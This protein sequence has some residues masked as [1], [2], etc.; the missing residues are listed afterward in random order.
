[1]FAAEPIAEGEV[2]AVWGGFIVQT[3]ERH[4]LPEIVERYTI[5]I[6]QEL[7]LMCGPLV[8]DAEYFNHSCDPNAGLQGQVVLVAMRPVAAGEH[9]CFD[10]AMSESDPTFEMSCA[11]G[12]AL[13]R[14][15]V[16]GND[17]RLPDLQRRYRG[18]FSPYIQRMI[19]AAR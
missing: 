4:Q 16:T 6:E 14:H 17:W 18:Y 5:Q 15:H 19:D 11:C 12:S 2:L 8:D 1:M 3:A 13:C 9:V 10:Y 7:H